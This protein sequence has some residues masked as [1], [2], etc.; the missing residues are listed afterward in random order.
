M[1]NGKKQCPWCASQMEERDMAC[2]ACKR[3]D[4]LGALKDHDVRLGLIVVVSLLGLAV[5]LIIAFIG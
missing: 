3:V 2:A 5:L 1:A 4:F